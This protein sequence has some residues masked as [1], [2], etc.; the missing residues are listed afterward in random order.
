MWGGSRAQ[1]RRDLLGAK[2]VSRKGEEG[3]KEVILSGGN[4]LL[5]HSRHTSRQF[6]F[7]YHIHYMK[8]STRFKRWLSNP[9]LQTFSFLL[10]F[11]LHTPSNLD[12]FNG[13]S[14]FSPLLLVLLILPG[15]NQLHPTEAFRF[16]PNCCF[17]GWGDIPV[18]GHQTIPWSNTQDVHGFPGFTTPHPEELISSPPC[19]AS[20]QPTKRH[21]RAFFTPCD[22][23]KCSKIQQHF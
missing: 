17:Q 20:P 5:Q 21:L 4:C 14:L 12:A 3:R 7:L 1:G 22:T 8:N 13:S 23:A 10:P 19:S 11:L 15:A 9:N 2:K 18:R 16:Q 6:C